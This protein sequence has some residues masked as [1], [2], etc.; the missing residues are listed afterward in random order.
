MSIKKAVNEL[1]D[2]AIAAAK[3]YKVNESSNDFKAG[4][5]KGVESMASLVE[6][7]QAVALLM[8]E[9]EG[10]DPIGSKILRGYADTLERL[11]VAAESI[12]PPEYDMQ[13]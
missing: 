10:A 8:A 5:V 3:N 13:P 9:R 2:D 6:I 12:I 11:L 7:T 1:R 4:Y